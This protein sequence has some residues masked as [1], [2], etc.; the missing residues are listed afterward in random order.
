M[1]LPFDSISHGQIAFGF[2]NVDSDMLLLDRYFFFASDF[3]FW[4]QALARES[5]QGSYTT[6]WPVYC[7]TD[8]WQIGDLHGAMA[9]VRHTG[10]IGEVYLRFPFPKRS[11]DFKQ[12]PEGA[13]TRD[14]IEGIIQKYAA[15]LN[16][17]FKVSFEPM[18]VSIGEY[19]FTK[20]S[21]QGLVAYVWRGGYP[22]WK[23]GKRPPYVLAMKDEIRQT[24][25]PLL[26][27]LF[28]SDPIS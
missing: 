4:M 11:E 15:P 1:P 5:P 2:F 8:P 9:G 6:S 19:R 18:E 24:S 12:N 16:I 22:R 17:P 27:D 14:E 13:R 3:C 28:C 10:F 25:S 23:D 26:K 20:E 7:I 21:F